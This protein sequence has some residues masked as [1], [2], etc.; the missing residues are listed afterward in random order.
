MKIIN[1]TVDRMELKDGSGG[2]IFFG[3]VF[4]I[5]GIG[6]S[7]VAYA[8]HTGGFFPYI[9]SAVFAVIGLLTAVNAPFINVSIDKSAGKIVIKKKTM[10]SGSNSEYDLTNVQTVELREGTY[11]IQNNNGQQQGFSMQST[12]QQGLSYQTIL[13]MKDGTEVPLENIKN[14]SSNSNTINIMGAST[15]VLMGGRGAMFAI[16]NQVAQFIG[17]PFKEI[18]PNGMAANAPLVNSSEIVN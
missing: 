6:S 15:P 1:Q 5:A 13:V 18:M 3:L 2:R 12:A 14:P 7:Y 16:S 8:N 17:V 11:I 4:V 10:I 9:F